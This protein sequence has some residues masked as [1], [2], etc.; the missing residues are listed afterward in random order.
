[1]KEIG[2]KTIKE[3]Y[4]N[5]VKAIVIIFYFLVINL[6]YENIDINVLNTGIQC[7]SILILF[8]AIYSFEKSYK[9]DDFNLT[10]EGIELL[11][12]AILSLT[13]E[14]NTTKYNFEFKPYVLTISYIFATYFVL[15]GL[16]IYTKEKKKYVDS[17]S[18]VREIVKKEEPTKKEATKK[19]KRESKNNKEDNVNEKEKI[20]QEKDNKKEKLENVAE[21]HKK[22]E[23]TKQKDTKIKN[24]SNTKKTNNSNSD[25]NNRNNNKESKAQNKSTNNKTQNKN[26]NT[27]KDKVQNEGNISKEK[28]TSNINKNASKPEKV[29][30]NTKRNKKQNKENKIEEGKK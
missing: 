7:F 8:G 23:K 4:I 24:K 6:I 9:K 22:T 16:V 19:T 12:L 30:E 3:I 21:G 14:H 29:K 18:D 28:K 25:K 5:I 20:K 1:M 26:N 17:L 27:K 10:I 11:I 15:K 13:I 2:E